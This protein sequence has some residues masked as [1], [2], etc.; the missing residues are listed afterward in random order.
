M[1]IHDVTTVSKTLEQSKRNFY[2]KSSPLWFWDF[3]LGFLKR[4]H[5]G[6]VEEYATCEPLQD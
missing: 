1:E 4:V 2:R 5:S 3:I 6:A